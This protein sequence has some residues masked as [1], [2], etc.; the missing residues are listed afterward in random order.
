MA[1]TISSVK[2]SSSLTFDTKKARRL[3][4]LS[5]E[6]ADFAEDILESRQEYSKEFVRGLRRSLK[7]ARAG[8]LKKIASLSDLR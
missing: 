2:R 5:T 3:F 1:Q 8:K 6:L 7:E 4:E